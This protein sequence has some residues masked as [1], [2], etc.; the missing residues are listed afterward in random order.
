MSLKDAKMVLSNAQ[1]ETT[2]AAH[3]STNVIDFGV[4]TPNKG[5]GRPI[6]AKLIVEEAVTSS[7]L[8]T[9]AVKLQ[10]SADNNSYSDLVEIIPATAKAT[11]VKGYEVVA[12]LPVENKRYVKGVITIGT[13]VLTA[14]KFTID[15]MD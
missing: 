1:A 12:L 7:G 2:V 15:L 9:V 6:R 3:D 11:L 4:A 13:A 10:H 14:G 5:E 8:A